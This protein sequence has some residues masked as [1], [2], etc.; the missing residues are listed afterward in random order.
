MLEQGPDF[1]CWFDKTQFSYHFV[2]PIHAKM[3]SIQMLLHFSQ[4]ALRVCTL[5]VEELQEEEDERERM[6]NRDFS[7]AVR[8]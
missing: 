4:I 6:P 7:P 5:E 1:C 2:H 3:F 8:T